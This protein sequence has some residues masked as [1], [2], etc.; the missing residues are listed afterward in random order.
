MKRSYSL[1]SERNALQ[2]RLMTLVHSM[3]DRSVSVSCQA[4]SEKVATIT[5]TVLGIQGAMT[6]NAVLAKSSE[7]DDIDAYGAIVE[8][9]YG[10]ANGFKYKL[11]GIE[12][13]QKLI[14]Q[15]VTYMSQRIT[16]I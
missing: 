12:E 10:F 16:R 14:K 11:S 2:S 15:Q 13:I 9:W 1:S 7:I 4:H 3:G 5:I 6:T 8:Y